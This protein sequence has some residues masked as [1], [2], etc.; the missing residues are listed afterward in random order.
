MS[1]G[2]TQTAEGECPAGIGLH[3]IMHTVSELG[4]SN[5]MFKR[6]M[7]Y[8]IYY[9]SILYTIYC[10]LY[11]LS[12]P[13]HWTAAEKSG[14]VEQLVQLHHLNWIWKVASCLQV[15]GRLLHHPLDGGSSQAGERSGGGQ[16]WI[17]EG[18]SYQCQRSNRGFMLTL[19]RAWTFVR[20]TT[21]KTIPPLHLNFCLTSNVVTTIKGRQHLPKARIQFCAFGLI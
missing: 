2:H 6:S 20:Q 12:V 7:L 10:F 18:K 9:T 16:S 5:L 11:Y 17:N 8:Y 21:R 14:V 15:F 1:K 19:R 3:A 13:V 4:Y